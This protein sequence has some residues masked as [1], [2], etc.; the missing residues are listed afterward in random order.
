M[1]PVGTWLLFMGDMSAVRVC[2]GIFFASFSCYLL[3][4]SFLEEG[5]ERKAGKDVESRDIEV[6][7]QFERAISSTGIVSQSPALGE[8]PTSDDTSIA[9]STMDSRDSELALKKK[10]IPWPELKEEEGG[11]DGTALVSVP[12]SSFSPGS[13]L[14]SL[15]SLINKNLSPLSKSA[16]P[17]RACMTFLVS[18]VGAGFFNGLLGVGGPPQMIAFALLQVHKDLVRGVAVSY[19]VLEM[20]VRLLSFFLVSGR[21]GMRDKEVTI[22]AFVAAASVSGFSLGTYLRRFADTRLILRLMLLLTT[23]G[24]A[25]M[26]DALDSPLVGGLFLLYVAALLFTLGLIRFKGL[27]VGGTE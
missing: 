5:R 14:F 26:V 7:P 12:S 19:N 11:E 27:W 20:P 2:T 13:V 1:V 25:I 17:F 9:A 21:G 23:L 8:S 22:L 18:G 4:K 16:T 15:E 24:A 3:I 6:P 10:Y